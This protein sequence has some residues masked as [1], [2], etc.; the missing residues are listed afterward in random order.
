M[1]ADYR[2][3]VVQAFTDVENGL[4]AYRYATEQERLER[5]AVAV[6][7]TA[8]DIARAQVLAGTS[9][10]VQALQAQTTLYNDLD[11]L[12]QA[13]LARFSALVDLYKALGGGWTRDDTTPPHP[14]L[15][16]GVL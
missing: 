11:L 9:D 6:A 14:Q 3:A 4:A 16:Q 12:A 13:R 8:A 1:L 2:K 5:Q 10:I 7:Q 15:F